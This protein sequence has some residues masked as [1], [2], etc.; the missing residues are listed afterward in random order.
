MGLWTIKRDFSV[1]HFLCHSKSFVFSRQ[2]PGELQM[3]S[4]SLFFMAS[5]AFS[6]ITFLLAQVVYGY[7]QMIWN[8]HEQISWTLEG[9]S[10]ETFHIA[11]ITIAFSVT[12]GLQVHLK[13]GKS[14]SLLQHFNEI[15]QKRERKTETRASLE[16]FN[17]MITLG[18]MSITQLHSRTICNVTRLNEQFF[19]ISKFT[20]F[21]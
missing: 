3:K 12:S 11:A 20:F 15:H 10:D 21:I 4:R 6:K 2:S 1:F 5:M 19:I 17:L 14:F 9:K 13:N 16:S 18:T 8:Y 7:E